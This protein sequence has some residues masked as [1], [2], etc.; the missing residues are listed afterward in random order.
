MK[1]THM[2]RAINRAVSGDSNARDLLNI[3][4]KEVV[5]VARAVTPQSLKADFKY[6]AT[7]YFAA[8]HLELKALERLAKKYLIHLFW[9]D[10]HQFKSAALTE[11]STYIDENEI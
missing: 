6:A 9:I 8:M 2:Q 10:R 1:L 5:H 7:Q 11:E 3:G 4:D